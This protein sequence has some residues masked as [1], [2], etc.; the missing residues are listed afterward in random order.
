MNDFYT[1][2]ITSTINTPFGKFSPQER[3]C[4]TLETIDSIRRKVSNA[5]ILLIDNSLMRFPEKEEE[6]I[7]SKVELFKYIEHNLITEHFNKNWQGSFGEVYLMWDAMRTLRQNDMIGKRIFKISGR[8]RLS[9]S[10]DIAAYES[11]ELYNKYVGIINNWDFTQHVYDKECKR[12]TTYFE[13]RLW[14][15]CQSLFDEYENLIPYIY[16][17]LVDVDSNYEVAHHSL[18]DHS[19]IAVFNPIHVEG[20][21]AY[22]AEIKVE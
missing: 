13:T 9:D 15:F 8:Y 12:R 1:F 11:L 7:K 14:S 20:H 18:L 3:F 4:Q 19:K 2:I 10:F 22:N 21:T 6:L 16:K 5:K 17:F